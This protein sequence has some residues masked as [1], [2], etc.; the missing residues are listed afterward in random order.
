MP[1]I[2]LDIWSDVVCPW[3][4][5]GKHRVE[6]ALAAAGLEADW[7]FHA[8]ELGARQQTRQPTLKHLAEKYKVSLEE[9]RTM[10]ERVQT[11][12]TELGIDINPDV[13]QTAASFD[14]HRLMVAAQK[15][16][17]GKPLMERLHRAYFSEGLDIS[18]HAVLLGLVVEVVLDATEAKRVLDTDAYSQ[19][20]ETAEQQAAAYQIGGVPYTVVNMQ[21]AISGA[22]SEETFGQAFAQALADAA[23]V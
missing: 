9:A 14:A 3:C 8:Y 6:R 4:W 18:D 20:V 5:I 7:R 12:G 22:Q 21:L 15:V 17:L 11:L 16:G 2:T 1:K 19:E 13:Q 23:K 10:T